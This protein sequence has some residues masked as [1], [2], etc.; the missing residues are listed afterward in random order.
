MI[1]IA[2][3]A[4]RGEEDRRD[5]VLDL[6]GMIENIT[7]WGCASSGDQLEFIDSIHDISLPFSRV[8]SDSLNHL[9]FIVA[10]I[11]R[12]EEDRGFSRASSNVSLHETYIRA[13]TSSVTTNATCTI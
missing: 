13:K 5:R 9:L 10:V 8:W 3:V 7:V 12:V 1:Y 6:T 2:S 11:G 4:T